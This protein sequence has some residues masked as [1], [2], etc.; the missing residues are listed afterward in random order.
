MKK[1]KPELHRTASRNGKARKAQA[2]ARPNPSTSFPDGPEPS[3][4]PLT[5]VARSTSRRGGKALILVVDGH[6]IFRQGLIQLINAEPDLMVCGAAGDVA[7]AKQMLEARSADLVLLEL[8]L[9]TGDV[10]ELIKG[11]K[12]R[13]PKLR[14]LILS[15]YDEALYA[16]RALRAGATGYVMKEEDPR[17]TLNALR[18][19]LAGEM[20]LSQRMASRLL[21]KL[22]QAKPAMR[23]GQ[24]DGLSDRELQVFRMLGTGLGSRM[25]GN[26]LHL[27]IKTIETYRENIKHKLG[28][29]NAAELVQL[30]TQ[31]VQTSVPTEVAGPPVIQ[32][33]DILVR[34][35]EQWT[36]GVME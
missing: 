8:R 10:F 5:A 25:I 1:P 24:V 2:A 30:A 18:A 11:W 13:H 16:E 23:D 33:S 32:A 20:Y 26:D 12:D 21:H 35:H 9:S 29:R 36:N 3:P 4:G 17:E 19:V 15:G 27:S 31:W 14:V 28:L 22:I 34:P 6:P 7:T